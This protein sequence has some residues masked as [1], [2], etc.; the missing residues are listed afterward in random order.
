MGLRHIERMAD[1]AWLLRSEPVEANALFE[2]L[3]ISVTSF[4]RNPEAWQCLQQDVIRALIERTDAQAE[5][6]AW[7]PGCATGEEAYSLAMKLIEAARAARKSC[8]VRIFASDVD[9]GALGLARAGLYPE[10][11]AA[12]VTPTRLQRFFVPDRHTFCVTKELREAVTFAPQNLLADP[13]FSRIDLISCRNVLMYLE[14]EA[15]RRV[16]SLLHFA[17]AEGGSLFLGSADT[18]W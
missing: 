18:I 12:D 15:Q 17:L 13:P 4:F 7:V 10:T 6:R 2:D 1:Y 14:P 8:S 3:L 5:L 11:I 16:V 9:Q